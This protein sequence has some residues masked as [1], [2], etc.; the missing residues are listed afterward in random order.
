MKEYRG[1]KLPVLHKKYVREILP[2]RVRLSHKGT[3]GK[4]GIIAGSEEYSGAA[5][6]AAAG[7]LRA[8]A[9]YTTLFTPKD[10]LPWYSLKAPEILLKGISG[11]G[12]YA[13]NEKNM[14]EV[15]SQD[16][17]AYGMGMGISDEVGKGVIYLLTHYEGKLIVD[18]DGL[19]SLA[20]Y[21]R[22]R[23]SE[24]LKNKKCQLVFTPHIKEFSRI[25]G[26]EVEEIEKDRLRWAVEFAK[27]HKLTLLLKDAYTLI[28]D[29]QFTLLNTTGNS[30][31]AKGGSGDLLSGIITGLCAMG[32]GVLEGACAGAYL[33]GKAAEI[34]VKEYGEY[35]LTASDC[36]Q[37]LG[38]AFLSVL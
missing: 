24:W 23:V 9:G 27:E 32:A 20:Q 37:M 38:K 31:Q 7:C 6:L 21:P 12:R 34:A 33:A 29:G 36:L 5:Y 15:L 26:K 17:L 19:N 14:T 10:I 8:G 1:E 18:A 30:G 2:K 13:F 4:G 11:G 28:T 16:A 35:S 22:E 25:V 3:Y